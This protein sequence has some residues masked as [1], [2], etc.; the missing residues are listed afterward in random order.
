MV[1]QCHVGRTYQFSFHFTQYVSHGGFLFSFQLLARFAFLRMLLISS[2]SSFNSPALK[3]IGFFPL[4]TFKHHAKVV[5]FWVVTPC[6]IVVGYRCFRGL[7]ALHLHFTLKI[8]AAW[9][10]ETV[11][12]YHNTIRRHNP[13]DLDLKHHRHENLKARIMHRV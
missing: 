11:V 9:T 12:S 3:G 5:I 4:S 2:V 7:C 1:E 6:S 8:D 10:S 13:E